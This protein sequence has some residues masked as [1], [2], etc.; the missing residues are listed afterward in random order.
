MW[1][2]TRDEG[3]GAIRDA[4]HRQLDP[5]RLPESWYQ[6]T[7]RAAGARPRKLVPAIALCVA[8]VL[9]VSMALAAVFWPD[10]IR[11]AQRE[12]RFESQPLSLEGVLAAIDS[13]EGSELAG[14][15]IQQDICLRVH[16]LV[17]DG[18]ELTLLYSL[19]NTKPDMPSVEHLAH[20][21]MIYHRGNEHSIP[22]TAKWYE[23]E[24][25]TLYC[26]ASIILR[27]DD[28]TLIAL[29][30]G[31]EV[32]FAVRR[33]DYH[34]RVQNIAFVSADSTAQVP[35]DTELAGPDSAAESL[36]IQAVSVE[37]GRLR[38]AYTLRQ[39]A[40]GAQH[41]YLLALGYGSTAQDAPTLVDPER[42]TVQLVDGEAVLEVDLRGGT[43][44]L[45]LCSDTEDLSYVLGVPWGV[46]IPVR[47]PEGLPLETIA[48]EK[49]LPL[50]TTTNAHLSGATLR[51]TEMKLHATGAALLF[52]I[53][54]LAAPATPAERQQLNAEVILPLLQGAGQN[55]T[56]TMDGQTLDRPAVQY[57]TLWEAGGQA[58]V[59]G[60]LS[61][62][63][64]LTKLPD[65]V[66][67]TMEN[68]AIAEKTVTLQ[69]K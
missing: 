14:Q 9:V 3:D 60:V 22:S 68:D 13:I 52:E 5:Q 39:K 15:A 49:A 57:T 2:N 4:L 11:R 69:V 24:T 65:R 53:T 21:S 1:Q 26:L 18:V 7:M 32:L 44:Q 67:L 10:V 27:D 58:R 19:Q 62:S 42:Q 38:V 45:A 8:C 6:S 34:A 64:Y 25:E 31:E 43:C 55:M 20:M 33:D 41:A 40:A 17:Y 23:P 30:D 56:L 63:T 66:T 61:W 46:S 37:D 28:G 51:L 36:R 50:D 48:L 12:N 47:G 59:S 16:Y 54:G 35:L 29:D